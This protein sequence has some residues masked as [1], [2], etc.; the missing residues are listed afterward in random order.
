MNTVWLRVMYTDNPRTTKLKQVIAVGAK[1]SHV[2]YYL[3]KQ[4]LARSLGLLVSARSVLSSVV[5]ND[6]HVRSEE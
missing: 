1:T 4:Q 6:A 2:S 3:K 5:N